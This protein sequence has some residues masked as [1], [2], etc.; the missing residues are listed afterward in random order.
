MG[1]FGSHSGD[2][3]IEWAISFEVALPSICVETLVAESSGA[4]LAHT[5]VNLT[6]AKLDDTYPVAAA[7]CRLEVSGLKLGDS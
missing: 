4:F 1:S 7:A 5:T 6:V 3:E 2:T